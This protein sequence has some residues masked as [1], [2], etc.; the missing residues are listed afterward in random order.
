MTAANLVAYAAQVTII[1]LACAGLPRLLGLRSPSVQYAFWRALL[2]V[3][4]LLPIAQPWRPGEMV[5]VPGPVQP[6]PSL[7]ATPPVLGASTAVPPASGIDWVVAA[8]LVIL[9]GVAMRLAW[10][11][12]GMIRLRRMG[13]RATEAAGGFEDLQTAIGAAAPILW[14]PEVRHP[15]TFGML[16]PVVLLPVA[17]KTAD[18]PAQRAV[19]AHEL[20]HVKRRDWGWVVAEEMIRSAF[21]FHPAMW[22][23][24]SRVQLARETVVDELSILATNARRTYLDTLLA[25]ADDTGLASPPAFSARRHLFHRVMLLS[26]EGE[27]SSIR[28]ALGSCV[29]IL[30]LGAGSWGAVK[31]FPL[32]ERM[33]PP[34][35]PPPPAR[36][37]QK[38]A[39]DPISA[40]AYHRTAVEYFEKAQTDTTSTTEEKR[41]TILKGIAAEDRALT[42]KP[43]FIDALVYKNIL[44]RM[45]AILTDDPGAMND[46]IKQADELRARAL[47]L[48]AAGVKS[49]VDDLLPPPARPVRGGVSGGVPGG[50]PSGVASRADELP[51][52]PPPPPPPPSPEYQE[53]IDRLKPVRIGGNVKTPIKTRDVKPVYP[54]IA[55]S[56]RVQGV[57]VVE[58]LVDA[59]GSVVEARVLR[60]IPLLDQAALEAVKQWEFV[61]TLLN[62]NP[63]AFLMTV[64]VSF[65]LQ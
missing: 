51:P 65:T 42:L 64:T 49:Q 47:V 36:E 26:K 2:A 12:V 39:R 4:L 5:F 14:S 15:V 52:P 34:P 31:A 21:W 54:P 53:L 30:A 37:A 44:L 29:L 25:F 3:C 59:G 11:G 63:T 7:S 57:V 40:Q 41:Q 33:Q 27:M 35:P 61:P 43:D 62:G 17:L 18:L 50:V 8:E 20:H 19:V 1:V 23:L 46:L 58:I 13:G 10:I 60:S 22:W 45:Q 32:Y 9:L 16:K 56:S 38:P 48:H 55:Q 6:P 28:V 24:V